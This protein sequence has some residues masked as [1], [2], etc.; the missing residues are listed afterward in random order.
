MPVSLAEIKTLRDVMLRIVDR[1]RV[2]VAGETY[3][4]DQ[5]ELSDMHLHATNEG[6]E[7]LWVANQ[8][9]YIIVGVADPTREH[10]CKTAVDTLKLRL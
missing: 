1:T 9:N 2:T 4:I 8:G 5:Y 3:T 7:H 10:Q 6:G